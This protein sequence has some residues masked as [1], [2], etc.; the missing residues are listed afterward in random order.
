MLFVSS[1]VVNFKLN[2]RKE[3]KKVLLSKE[4]RDALRFVIAII[5]EPQGTFWELPN[6]QN[7]LWDSRKVLQF[8]TYVIYIFYVLRRPLSIWS[9]IMFSGNT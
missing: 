3:S 5:L 1:D 9:L 8:Y 2:A 6:P 4:A 7:L